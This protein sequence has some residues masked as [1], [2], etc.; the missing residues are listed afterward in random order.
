MGD[1]Q[2]A[3]DRSAATSYYPP[4]PIPIPIPS[5]QIH[6]VVETHHPLRPVHDRH[7][8]DHAVHEGLA[9]AHERQHGEVLGADVRRVEGS[10][11]GQQCDARQASEVVGECRARE[12]GHEE[13]DEVIVRQ[14]RMHELVQ[15]RGDERRDDHHAEQVGAEAAPRRLPDEC[16][17]GE[18][19]RAADH[20][21]LPAMHQRERGHH[22]E[23]QREPRA[24][25]GLHRPHAHQQAQAREPDP[26]ALTVLEPHAPGR[27]ERRE[28]EHRPDSPSVT[29]RVPGPSSDP[30]ISISRPASGRPVAAS[31][32]RARRLLRARCCAGARPAAGMES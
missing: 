1:S 32:P 3:A 10:A 18:C 30:S 23:A 17:H 19:H 15:P 4:S 31:G 12:D 21:E 11:G 27:A 29:R 14:P 9:E 7:G 25:A 8:H 20:G 26:L 16:Q 28:R 2:K 13:V 6:S 5:P 22:Q 24:D